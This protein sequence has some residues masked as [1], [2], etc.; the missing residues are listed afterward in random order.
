[1]TAGVCCVLCRWLPLGLIHTHTSG[2]TFGRVGTALRVRAPAWVRLARDNVC[3]CVAHA[4]HAKA[5]HVPSAAV[6]CLA[7]WIVWWLL[8]WWLLLLLLLLLLL[9]QQQQHERVAVL[10]IA[11]GLCLVLHKCTIDRALWSGCAVGSAVSAH[12]VSCIVVDESTVV[13]CQAETCLQRG[14]SVFDPYSW[15]LLF[16]ALRYA[17]TSR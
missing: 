9:Q 15:S 12:C 7:C 10:G 17:A 4:T 3:A 13:A 5:Q 11:S 14:S 1:M 2:C 16:C 8:L 6:C